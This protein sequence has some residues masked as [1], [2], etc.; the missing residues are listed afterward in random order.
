MLKNKKVLIG[1]ITAVILI[2]AVIGIIC[3]SGASKEKEK[4]PGEIIEVLPEGVEG[5]QEEEEDKDNSESSI[6]APTTWE[7]G[8]N[9]QSGTSKPNTD[10]KQENTENTE[11]NEKDNNVSG[12]DTLEDEEDASYG[13][14]L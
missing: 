12:D 6:D 14:I 4:R 11:E 2:S 13:T 8:Q 9:T 7:E 10:N 3:W 5:L 1:I